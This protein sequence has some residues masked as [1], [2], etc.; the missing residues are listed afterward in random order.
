MLDVLIRGA[1]MNEP[2]S[3]ESMEEMRVTLRELTTRAAI[4]DVNYRY[5]QA[6]DKRD[7]DLLQSCFSPEARF[8]FHGT[9]FEG[10]ENI[11]SCITRFFDTS[12]IASTHFM[13]R[14]AIHAAGDEA[15]V[16]TV[17]IVY[18]AEEPNGSGRVKTRGI[19]YQDRFVLRDGQWLIDKRVHRAL[20]MTD[21]VSEV[22]R[23][24]L[25]PEGDGKS[26]R[27]I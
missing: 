19:L 2:T 26:E 24:I 12:Y 5:A 3:M 16:E 6:H 18:L 1:K 4:E 8:E 21:G 22:P 9:I 10:V 13:G 27:R 11:L 15:E 14:P 25:E 23:N 20:W 17:A 7:A